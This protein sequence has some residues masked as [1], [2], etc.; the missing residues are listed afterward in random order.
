M[1]YPDPFDV[2]VVGTFLAGEIH[3]GEARQAAGR[4]WEEADRCVPSSHARS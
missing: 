4:A 1:Q 2:I 3:V